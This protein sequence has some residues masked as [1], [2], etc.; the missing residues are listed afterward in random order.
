MTETERDAIDTPAEGL[1]VY[2]TDTKT[3]DLYDGTAWAAI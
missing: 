1:V 3:I 2:N